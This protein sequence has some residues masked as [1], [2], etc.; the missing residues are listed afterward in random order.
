MALTIPFADA[1]ELASRWRPLT[2]A[3]EEIATVLLGDA[4]QMILDEDTRGIYADATDPAS[5]TLKRIVCAMAKRAMLAG[6]DSVASTQQT[7]GPYSVTQTYSN[8]TGDLYLTAA[9][10]QALGFSRQRAGSVDMWIPPES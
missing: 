1:D 5:L 6:G 4:S 3:E 2:T 10:R 9:E 8:P 7:A